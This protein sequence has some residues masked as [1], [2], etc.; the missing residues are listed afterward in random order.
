MCSVYSSRDS[1]S[2]VSISEVKDQA[3]FVLS[4]GSTPPVAAAAVCVMPPSAQP[5][6]RGACDPHTRL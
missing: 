5:P 1:S 4:S 2:D 6:L 3:T